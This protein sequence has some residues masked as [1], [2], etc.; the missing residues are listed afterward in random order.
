[1]TFH[2]LSQCFT[3]EGA[4][5]MQSRHYTACARRLEKLTLLDIEWLFPEHIDSSFSDDNSTILVERS[6]GPDILSYYI[7]VIL[8]VMASGPHVCCNFC[9]CCCWRCFVVSMLGI[10]LPNTLSSSPKI[11]MRQFSS[12]SSPLFMLNVI[13]RETS[14]RFFSRVKFLST[15]RIYERISKSV[16]RCCDRMFHVRISV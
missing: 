8:I 1:M 11:S 15:A 7:R 16:L 4:K 10:A 6:S 12:S 14:V 3:R 5:V 13:R 9:C 2:F